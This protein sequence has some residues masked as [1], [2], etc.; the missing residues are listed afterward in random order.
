MYKD[1]VTNGK[2][3]EIAMAIAQKMLDEELL[4]LNNF[5][6]DTDAILQCVS[7]MILKHL[8][9]YILVIGTVL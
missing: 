8:E 3:N 5:S 2:R 1:R 7:S 4:E 9:D 6:H